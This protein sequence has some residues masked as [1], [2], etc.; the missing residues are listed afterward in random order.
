MRVLIPTLCSGE[1]VD[2]RFYDIH[3]FTPTDALESKNRRAWSSALFQTL[4]QATTAESLHGACGTSPTC[5][6]TIADTEMGEHALTFESLINQRSLASVKNL[7]EATGASEF[8]EYWYLA[9]WGQFLG[10]KKANH[11]QSAD[12][13]KTLGT[14]ACERYTEAVKA[15]FAALQKPVPVCSV[16]LGT[17]KHLFIVLDFSELVQALLATNAGDLP[18]TIGKYL[19]STAYDGE[20]ILRSPWTYSDK[21]TFRVYKEYPLQWVEFAY[22]EVRSGTRGEVDAE[23]LLLRDYEGEGQMD[24]DTLQDKGDSDFKLRFPVVVRTAPD[25]TDGLFLFTTDGAEWR[26]PFTDY[27]NCGVNVGAELDVAIIPGQKPSI[28]LRKD[29]E[30]CKVAA[31]FVKGW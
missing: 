9:W 28:N 17:D 21:G 13:A 7:M 25:G 8:S 24:A 20:V 2:P 15:E 1:V 30:P 14:S 18:G 5:D 16:M 3:V 11:P 6:V 27:V 29:G 23:M 26:I 10:M 19:D 4:E 12:N 22:E 31:Q